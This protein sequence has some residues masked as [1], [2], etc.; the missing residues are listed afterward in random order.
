MAQVASPVIYIGQGF[1]PKGDKD[2]FVLP[3]DVR[4][5]V[6]D[7]SGDKNIMVVGKHEEWDCLI[8]CGTSYSTQLAGEI[9][10]EHQLALSN[11]LSSNRSRR[12]LQLGNL[13]PVSFDNSGRFVLP[14]HFKAIAGISD[15]IYIHGSLDF[16]TLWSPDVLAAQQGPEWLVPQAT[17]ASYQS[18]AARG[19]K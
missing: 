8:C 17:C 1:S 9:R 6:T 16:F 3:A 11:G 18:S 4:K 14:A 10:D 15:A 12:S 2:R 13:M 19:R 5:L 7:A